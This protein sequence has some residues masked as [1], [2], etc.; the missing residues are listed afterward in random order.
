MK[1]VDGLIGRDERERVRVNYVSNKDLKDENQDQTDGRTRGTTQLR[2]G[3]F[4]QVS[5]ADVEI[6]RYI[7]QYL[8]HA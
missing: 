1:R 7:P 5:G 3:I 4:S 8:W 2:V 6:D